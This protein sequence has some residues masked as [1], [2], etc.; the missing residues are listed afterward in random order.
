MILILLGSTPDST[1]STRLMYSPLAAVIFA[2]APSLNEAAAIFT[3]FVRLP[4]ASTLPGTAT[5]WPSSV[6]LSILLRLIEAR[7][8]LDLSRS[9]ARA[10]QMALPD[11]L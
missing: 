5:Y 2:M 10:F 3:G 11:A 6:C 1:S 9:S 4:A 7:L 8:R